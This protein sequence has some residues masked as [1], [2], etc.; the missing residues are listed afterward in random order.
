MPAR[1]IIQLYVKSTSQRW[2]K[3]AFH[4]LFQCLLL[5]TSQSITIF[6]RVSVSPFAGIIREMQDNRGSVQYLA[7]Y[8][9]NFAHAAGNKTIKAEGWRG[10]LNSLRRNFSNQNC[11]SFMCLVVLARLPI[12][13]V[14]YIL[15]IFHTEKM[16]SGAMV[17]MT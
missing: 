9:H 17:A 5:G 12:V 10:E 1:S 7:P 8:I 6:E 15:N 16:H 13:T 14:S 3:G 11:T 4:F 2:G